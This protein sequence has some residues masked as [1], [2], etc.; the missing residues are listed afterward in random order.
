MKT[1]STDCLRAIAHLSKPMQDRIIADVTRFML[2][3]EIPEKLPSMRKALFISL[4]LQLDPEADLEALI[5]TVKDPKDFN[6]LKDLKDLKDLNDVKVTQP[7]PRAER[8]RFM[9]AFSHHKKRPSRALQDSLLRLE[10]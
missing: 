4:V 10:V 6:D 3:G 2:T 5:N 9:H 8:R 7:P 1:F